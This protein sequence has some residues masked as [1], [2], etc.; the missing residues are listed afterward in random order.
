MPRLIFA[1][2]VLAAAVFASDSE[3][4]PNVNSRYTI[5]SCRVQGYRSSN[6]S[7]ELRTELES[8]VGQKFDQ[9]LLDRISARIRRDLRVNKVSAKVARGSDPDYVRIEF[10]IENQRTT[11][12]DL[13]V[14]MFTYN[15]K[16]GW[17]GKG[18]VR[19][20]LAGNNLA[21]A[22]LSDGNSGVDRFSGVEAKISRRLS[23]RYSIGF[24]FDSYKEDWNRATQE[25]MAADPARA[26]GLY[27]S[28]LNFQPS[29]TIVVAEP[30]TFSV[31]VSVQSLRGQLP[32]A[33][34]ES[35]NAVL[36]TL[37]YHGSWSNGG[38]AQLLD[39]AYM[40]RAGMSGLG[41][42]FEFVR[43]SIDA[44]YQITMGRQVVIV[45]FL[46]GGISG[47]AP[48]F[49]RFVLGNSNTLRGWNK[50]ELDPLGGNHVVHGSVEYR[51]RYFQAFYDRGAIWDRR[52]DAEQKQSVGFGVRT[53][54]KDGILLAVAFPLQNGRMDPMFIAEIDF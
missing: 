9:S 18:E 27:D 7:A 13:G 24:E 37:R 20:T 12:F 10:F 45:S 39:A 30:L 22:V 2:L 46:A 6:I 29:L 48:L 42:D 25:A 17:S 19:T 15:S 33:G 38:T 23:G 14:P 32:A 44:R 28:R 47:T 21:L 51:W 50:F 34:N 40:L 16:Q 4:A 54:S 36:S 1:A 49:E 8:V 41:S 5:E 53:G 3:D 31:G 35:S 26:G 52:I 43:N 11:D